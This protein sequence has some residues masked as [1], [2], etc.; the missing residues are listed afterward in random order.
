M[1]YRFVGAR[2]GERVVLAWGLSLVGGQEVDSDSDSRIG[3]AVRAWPGSFERADEEPVRRR[4]RV[5][6]G[7]PQVAEGDDA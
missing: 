6:K 2:V 7:D 1:R 5:S 3:D 4:R